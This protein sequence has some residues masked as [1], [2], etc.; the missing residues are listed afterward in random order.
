VLAIIDLR[1]QKHYVHAAR[2]TTL[3]HTLKGQLIDV[4][5]ACSAKSQNIPIAA[6]INE[7]A[8]F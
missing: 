4:A 1:A 5:A 7:H 3:L 6:T 2:K 8:D